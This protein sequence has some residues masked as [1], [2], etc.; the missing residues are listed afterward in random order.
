M[1]DARDLVV[2]SVAN[3]YLLVIAD[4]SRVDSLRAQVTTDQ[5][6]YDR[7]ADQK[8]AGTV[9]GIDVLRSQVQLQQQQQQ[10]LAQE[11]QFAKDKLALGRVIGLPAGQDFNIAESAPYSAA[12]CNDA[13]PG[14]A[15]RLRPAR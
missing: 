6:I 12:G 11:N 4:S 13:G 1:Q 3:A 15:Y 14:S 5:A 9:P 10:L 2:Q 8:R 7:T